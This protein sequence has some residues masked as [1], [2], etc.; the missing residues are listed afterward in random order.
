M[1]ELYQEPLAKIP[2]P[3]IT[4][5]NRSDVE[6]VIKFVDSAL[7]LRASDKEV[8]LT[9]IEDSIEKLVCKLF[10]LSD[11]DIESLSKVPKV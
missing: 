3:T 11:A 10:N 8:N 6:S 1:L 7:S 5:E 9:E 2:L 4:N